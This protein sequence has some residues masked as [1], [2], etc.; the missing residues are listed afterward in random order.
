MVMNLGDSG[1]T[2]KPWEVNG[3]VLNARHGVVF[4]VVVEI[5]H[6]ERADWR[7]HID[8]RGSGGA[9]VSVADDAILP[10]DRI[11]F[12]AEWRELRRESR[13]QRKVV[14]PLVARSLKF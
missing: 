1:G 8:G 9:I 2:A 5:R 6:E 12:K 7:P 13:L 3:V 14:I 4:V 10:T 11:G